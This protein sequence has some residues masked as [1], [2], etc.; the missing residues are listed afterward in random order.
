MNPPESN[1]VCSC[2]CKSADASQDPTAGKSNRRRNLF[3]LVLGVGLIAGLWL[4][5]APLQEWVR[6]RATLANDSPTP[7]VVA[8]MINKAED[9]QASLLLAWNSGKII[10]RE[11]AISEL[12]NVFPDGQPLP[13]KFESLLLS[14]ALDPDVDV[15]ETAFGILRERHDPALL[16]LAAAQ[17]HNVDQS[18]RL[19]G[20]QQFKSAPAAVGVPLVAPLL[21]DPDPAVAGWSAKLLENWSGQD[22][23]IKLADTVQVEDK[24]TGLQVFQAEGVAKTRTAAAKAEAWWKQH[25]SEYP[26][27]KLE[28]PPAAY[29]AR[30]AVSAGDFQLRTVDGKKVSLSN[31]RGKVVL[32]NFWT[33]WCTACVGEIPELIAL[34]KQHADN[35]V[36]LGVSLDYVPDEGGDV[37]GDDAGQKLDPNNAAATA[38]LFKKIRAKVI[39]T[40]E[41]RGINYP[42]LLDKNNEVGGHFNGGELPTTVIVD[43]RGNVRRRFVGARDQAV[44]EAMIAEARQ[45]QSPASP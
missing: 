22:F 15:R 18:L 23:G 11:V 8:A 9:P 10:Q 30:Q 1:N 43:A 16:A 26:A 34:Q 45:P 37:G 3:A 14:A 44:F 35:L 6:D 38:A 25:Q 2:G 28:V 13:P 41:T 21:D 39:R 40:M 4:L 36:I 17:L 5:R 27:V 42:I 24:K 32:V 33:T 12:R 31:F 20:L 29:A 7:E 19:L